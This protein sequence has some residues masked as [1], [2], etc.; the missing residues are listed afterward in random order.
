M[1]GAVALIAPS[2]ALAHA[3]LTETTPSSDAVLDR[4]PARIVL[5]FNE[6][7]TTVRSSIR[8]FDANVSRVDDGV[9]EQ[10]RAEEV[11]VGV[12]PGLADGTYV[13]AWRVLSGDSHP[14]R[15]AYAFSVGE[16]TEAGES[17]IER[18][19]D[20]EAESE[21]VDVAL[22]VTR[23]VGLA[24]ILLCVGG[25]ALVALAADPRELRGSWHWVAL[26]AA[27]SLLAF[28]SIAWIALT[29]VKAAGLGLGDVFSWSLS[30]EI[31]ET[32]FGR[33]WAAR[34]LLAVALA[35]VAAVAWRRGRDLSIPLLV[36]AGSIAVTPALSG[37]ARV[38]GLLA[39]LADAVHVI[40]AGVWVGGLAFLALVLVEA[41][42]ERWSLAARIVPAFS[43]LA[44]V[45]V[46][47]LVATGIVG[48]LSQLDSWQALWETTYGRLLLAKVA[49]LVPL[50]ALGAFN[51]RVSVP[52]LRSADAD[53]ETRRRFSRSVAVELVVMLVIV[54][55]TTA[56]VAEPPAKAQAAD[57]GGLVVREG[58]IGPYGY[59]LTVD[60]AQAGPNTTH[61]YLLDSTGQLA[62]VDEISL[63]ATLPE[64]DVGPLE[65]AIS[66]AGPGHATGV[67][68]VPLPGE[69][70][71]Q[72]DVREGEFDEWSTDID[73]PLERESS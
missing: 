40:A 45:S 15:G 12:P 44:V 46:I 19:L 73:V 42:S 66:P 3:V 43:S 63:S 4:A 48:G 9:V 28:D 31:L 62:E 56:L 51:N 64:Q 32:G 21:S 23:F 61:V 6:P 33:A 16:P 47:A 24:L 37:H 54:G 25:V 50:V 29:G 53:P 49:L 18:V 58:D 55:V 35:V 30:R 7:V 57:S 22:A 39:M 14:I 67:V 11:L 72:L 52:R 26:V 69:W 1:V 34:G 70:S 59:T 41:G 8:V 20:R 38:E 17:L 27:S 5:R 13:V 60:P 68:R 65:L 36:L 71:F 2:P 10:P